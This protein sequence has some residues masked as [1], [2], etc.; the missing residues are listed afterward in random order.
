M[1]AAVDAEIC[2][3]KGSGLI[4]LHA[5][6]ATISNIVSQAKW[7]Y[8]LHFTV[9]LFTCCAFGHSNNR[10]YKHVSQHLNE[11]PCHTFSTNRALEQ[12]NTCAINN[13]NC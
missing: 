1:V 2:Y 6:H 12:S 9:I 8:I 10:S 5:L 3:L 4:N 11:E 7:F 13:C